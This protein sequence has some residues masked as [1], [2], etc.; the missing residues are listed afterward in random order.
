[1]AGELKPIAYAPLGVENIKTT[2]VATAYP[3]HANP[4]P[5]FLGN[6]EQAA[7]LAAW[8]AQYERD[9]D[10]MAV[11]VATLEAQLRQLTGE[12]PKATGK[13]V[14]RLAHNI[15]LTQLNAARLENRTLAATVA[16]LTAENNRLTTQDSRE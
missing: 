3:C 7:K 5:L 4:V 9:M 6:P 1:M 12:E 16:Q 13:Q 8:E 2:F 11:K 14:S 10:A 15:V